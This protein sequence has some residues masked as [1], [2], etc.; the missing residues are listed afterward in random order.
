MGPPEW[1]PWRLEVLGWRPPWQYKHKSRDEEEMGLGNGVLTKHRQK[2][3]AIWRPHVE[4]KGAS[5]AV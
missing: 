1:Q 3:R 4:E 5:N 2:Q